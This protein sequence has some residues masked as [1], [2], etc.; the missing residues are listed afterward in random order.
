MDNKEDENIIQEE[1]LPS[2]RNQE[3]DFAADDTLEDSDAVLSAD[4][5]RK[6]LN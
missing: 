6:K 2:S 1:S 4:H 5:V 3:N